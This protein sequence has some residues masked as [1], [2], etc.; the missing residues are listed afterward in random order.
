MIKHYISTSHSERLIEGVWLVD[1]VLGSPTFGVLSIQFDN[2]L[3]TSRLPDVFH[4]GSWTRM[5]GGKHT[6][7]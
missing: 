4:A 5:G 7:R 3:P 2:R 1:H 6:T